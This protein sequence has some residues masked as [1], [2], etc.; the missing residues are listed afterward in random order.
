MPG[1]EVAD[2]LK[3][4]LRSLAIATVVLYLVLSGLT[5][6]VYIDA[7]NKRDALDKVAKSTNIALCALKNDLQ[8]RVISSQEFLL[9]HPKGIPG[10][11]AATLRQSIT[12]QKATIKA[13]SGLRCDDP[14]AAP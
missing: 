3:R 9:D 4:S 1:S 11:S 12:N 7:S 13:L 2:S 14:N 5:A 8:T 6:Y 10:I